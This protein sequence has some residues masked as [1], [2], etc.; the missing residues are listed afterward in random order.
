MSETRPGSDSSSARA[1]YAAA[2][3]Q[4]IDGLSP[5]ERSALVASHR[6]V[7]RD[8]DRMLSYR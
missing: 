3:K 4:R 8:T 7:E 2:A 1:A 6:R 5:S